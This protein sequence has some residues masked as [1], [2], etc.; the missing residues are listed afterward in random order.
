ML[1]TITPQASVEMP[2]P[3]RL[4]GWFRWPYPMPIGRIGRKYAAYIDPRS[5]V[6]PAVWTGP[7]YHVDGVFGVDANT[8]LG[9]YDGDFSAAKK[10]IFSAITA[11]N[12]TGAPYR[13]IVK[14]G[15]YTQERS[16]NGSGGQAGVEPTQHCA[17]IA[18]GGIVYHVAGTAEA[19]WVNDGSGTNTYTGGPSN[20]SRVFD[21]LNL[22]IHGSYTELVNVAD[23]STVRA[24]AGSWSG[25]GTKLAIRRAD[26]LTPD[27]EN[28]LVLRN[29]DTAA[30]DS[31]T[32]DLYF[33]GFHFHGG[34]FG[35]LWIDPV[36]TRNVVCVDCEAAYSGTTANPLD[37]FRIRRVQGLVLMVRCTARKAWKDGFNYHDDDAADFSMR[38]M[39][40][41][42]RGYSTGKTG[43]SSNNNLTTH[44]F[45]ILLDLNGDYRDGSIGADVHVIEGT[46]TVL[47]G[48]T[49]SA[50]VNG[51]VQ[52]ACIRATNNAVLY[53]ENINLTSPGATIVAEGAASRVILRGATYSGVAPASVSG[54]SIVTIT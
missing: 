25:L 50:G 9:V 8:G 46:Q 27:S 19:A 22:D 18:W 52:L 30:F 41:D 44:D 4:P 21:R 51:G 7:A 48:T 15:T 12:A 23:Q 28:T 49:I 36:S 39:H 26:G 38:V 6:N 1:P 2:T 42:C 11:G 16:I 54:G 31:C 53:G 3:V 32:T 20:A 17:F 5:Y 47:L 45:V 40:I 24:T 43:S 34:T 13:V 10:S 29:I 35:A 37:A 14:A 33:E